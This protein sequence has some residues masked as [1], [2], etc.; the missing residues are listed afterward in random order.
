MLIYYVFLA[1][2]VITQGLFLTPLA[3]ALE[4]M[5]FGPGGCCSGSVQPET[6]GEMEIGLIDRFDDAAAD[7]AD[8]A[9]SLRTR[10][11]DFLKIAGLRIVLCIGTFGVTQAVPDFGLLT[12]LT[13]GFGNNMLAFVFV[14][15]LYV[16]LR[17]TAGYWA[18]DW[19]STRSVANKIG[20]LVLMVLLFLFGISLLILAVFSTVQ[21]MLD[22]GDAAGST[23]SN[24]TTI[25]GL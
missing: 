22:G 19:S 24:A 4:R 13:G 6:T 5:W 10:F 21:S 12:G 8:A 11:V 2:L 15:L 18:F 14:P 23:P 16:K 9:P 20:Q 17:H 7:V 1:F 25:E 3:Q